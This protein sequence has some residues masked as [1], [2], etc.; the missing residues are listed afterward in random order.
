MLVN[1]IGF[2][3]SWFGL[4]LFG[5]LF[6]P[7]T[8]FWLCVH[9]YDSKY[10]K[11]ECK[12]IITITVIGILIDTALQSVNF[13]IFDQS[14]F[15]PMWLVTLW[16]AFAATLTKILKFLDKSKLLQAVIGFIF[17]PLSYLGGAQLASVEFGQSLLI[18][19]FVLGSIWS[20]LMMLFFYL[21][22][23]FYRQVAVND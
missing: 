16:A 23:L 12:L 15:I 10:P 5:E 14:A 13:F 21:K 7:F 2:N 6:I 8:F 11:V 3:I 18:T 9:L 19:Y 20:V 17:P 4:V 1:F 22:T